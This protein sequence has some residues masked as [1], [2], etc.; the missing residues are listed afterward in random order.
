MVAGEHEAALEQFIEM[1][2]RNRAFDDGAPR[3][4]LLDAFRV[5]PDEDL[6][7]R[8]RRRMSALLLV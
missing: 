5:V 2:A 6:V 4:L 1:L 7:G 3:K 8:Y